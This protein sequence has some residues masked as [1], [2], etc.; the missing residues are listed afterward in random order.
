MPGSLKEQFLTV[1][2]SVKAPGSLKVPYIIAWFPE[3][4]VF[5]RPSVKAN[6]SLEGGSLDPKLPD[7]SIQ[8]NAKILEN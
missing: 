8:P 2:G 3:C 1:S 5:L 4:C 6:L 7:A